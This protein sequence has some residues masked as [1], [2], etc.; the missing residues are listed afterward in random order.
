M[1][2]LLCCSSVVCIL[3][4]RSLCILKDGWG[5]LLSGELQIWRT[6]VTRL[7]SA[8]PHCVLVYNAL[9]WPNMDKENIIDMFELLYITLLYCCNTLPAAVFRPL[10]NV[11]ANDCETLFCRITNDKL[12]KSVFLFAPNQ[13]NY[14]C[15]NGAGF[16][17]SCSFINTRQDITS[18]SVLLFDIFA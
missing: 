13:N 5:T 7:N 1:R 14:A 15:N 12:L 11:L 18:H 2:N 17:Q 4:A 9:R 6:P 3:L 10:G 16:F 8:R